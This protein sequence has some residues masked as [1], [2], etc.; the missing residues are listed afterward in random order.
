M[1]FWDVSPFGN[2]SAADFAWELDEA[3][4]E[5]RIEMVGDALERAAGADDLG[6]FDAPRAV[7]AAALVAAQYPG[8]PSIPSTYG[9]STPM[10][11]FPGYLR[12]LAIEALDRVAAPSSWL[13]EFWE[14]ASE[15][16]A[17]RRTITDLLKALDPPQVEVLF[18]L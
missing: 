11:Q 12:R 9:P 18:D 7:A 1:G 17:W 3:T 13:V 6:L 16:A 4:A 14:E 8:G 15:V 2:D 5:A 10:P